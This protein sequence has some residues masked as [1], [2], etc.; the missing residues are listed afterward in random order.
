MS[1]APIYQTEATGPLPKLND[2]TATTRSSLLPAFTQQTQPASS[3]VVLS[4]TLLGKDHRGRGARQLRLSSIFWILSKP[5]SVCS[6][7][8]WCAR[9]VSRATHCKTTAGK[10]RVQGTCQ[11]THKWL[12]YLSLSSTDDISKP[13][14]TVAHRL[15]IKNIPQN[16][17]RRRHY[18]QNRKGIPSRYSSYTVISSQFPIR[19]CFLLTPQHL[20]W[21][22]LMGN[23]W[24]IHACYYKRWYD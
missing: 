17:R 22:K 4:Y 19:G 13:T 20:F 23:V 9:G 10:V 5:A 7:R 3:A 14:H 2:R 12:I 11:Q 18:T 8:L 21:V 1:C 16:R 15:L 6:P 24:D